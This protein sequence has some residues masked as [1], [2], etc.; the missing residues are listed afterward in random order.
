MLTTDTME[1]QFHV[2]HLCSETETGTKTSV[3][4]WIL[5]S[6]SISG[7]LAGISLTASGCSSVRAPRCWQSRCADCHQQQ[8]PPL[9]AQSSSLHALGRT[10]AVL[11]R[12]RLL[13]CSLSTWCRRVERRCREDPAFSEAAS[14][15]DTHQPTHNT[16]GVTDM[17]SAL[18]H[19]SPTCQLA[20][21]KSQLAD[22]SSCWQWNQLTVTTT[23]K[24]PNEWHRL[25]QLTIW[26]LHFIVRELI[27]VV[28]NSTSQSVSWLVD[29]L[30][31]LCWWVEMSATWPATTINHMHCFCI[32]CFF[33]ELLLSSPWFFQA[34]CRSCVCPLLGQLGWRQRNSNLVILHIITDV[35]QDYGDGQKSQYTSKSRYSQWPWYCDFLQPYWCPSLKK[36]QHS[37]FIHN[38]TLNLQLAR[39][40]H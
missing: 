37:C 19:I 11:P 7:N 13:C 20:D 40:S 21:I 33:Q 5:E 2:I 16:A 31:F 36:C 27:I 26:W 25:P 22:W 32:T 6:L 12:T 28:S 8:Q 1:M 24:S 3:D 18:A 34:G 4:E 38:L 10:L 30:T 23:V 17:C 9:P 15:F 29:K 39:C 14:A 35:V